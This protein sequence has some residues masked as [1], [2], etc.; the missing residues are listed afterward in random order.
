MVVGI[1]AAPL[2]AAFY[3]ALYINF[4]AFGVAYTTEGAGYTVNG[5]GVGPARIV[6]G[7]AYLLPIIILVVDM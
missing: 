1:H 5:F 2:T 4:A 7:A 6:H 3:H